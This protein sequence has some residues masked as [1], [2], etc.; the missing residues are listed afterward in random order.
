MNV[1]DLLIIL[2]QYSVYSA[3]NRT[4]V[5][6][7]GGV[8]CVNV[9]ST[10]SRADERITVRP[11]F[12]T[13]SN[14]ETRSHILALWFSACLPFFAVGVLGVRVQTPKKIWT[15]QQPVDFI[16]LSILA[17]GDFWGFAK[18]RHTKWSETALSLLI[19]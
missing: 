11:Y 3:R 7:G 5:F 17:S 13:L 4:N 10:V 9:T 18:K 19:V 8:Q 2:I 6:G 12:H 14:E 1:K 16:S 15:K